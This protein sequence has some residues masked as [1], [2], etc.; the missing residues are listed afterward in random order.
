MFSLLIFLAVLAALVLSHEFGHFIVA[1]KNGIK[2]DE[3][4]FGFPPRLFGIRRI[5]NAGGTT[6]WQIIWGSQDLEK[7]PLENGSSA[8]TLYSLNLIPLGGFVKIKGENGEDKFSPDSFGGKPFWQ[9]ASVLVAG[10]VMNVLLAA[11]LISVGYM[12]GMPQATDNLP[13]NTPVTNRHTE[14]AAVLEGK[15]AAAA[16]LMVGDT[17]LAIGTFK[18]PGPAEL[19]TY[20][21]A[22]KNEDI[23][24]TVKRGYS[25]ITKSIHPIVYEDTG[26]GGLGV[27]IVEVGLVKY[28]WYAAIY[29]GFIAT[30]LYLWQIVLSLFLLLKGLIVGQ[31]AAGELT[32]P[33]GVAVM[34]GRAARM[35]ISYLLQFT[36][37][38]SLNLAIVNILPIPALDGGRLLFLVIEKIR[39]KANNQKI[40]QWFHTIG[41]CLL[42]LLVLTI[43]I[44]DVGVFK[45]SLINFFHNL[46]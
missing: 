19:Q 34:T 16:G 39:G 4:G 31:G 20:I 27:A 32:G 13:A 35:G 1:R 43:T 25:I 14:I 46:F 12:A 29:H 22:H 18:N 28:S 24:V 42:L 40:E 45:G 44:K 10:V 3:F 21:D 30:G 38:L 11:V 37:V 23:T 6:K 9:K 7:F 41:Y 26:K 33:V 8:G 17:F 15:P 5:T 36:A 2:V